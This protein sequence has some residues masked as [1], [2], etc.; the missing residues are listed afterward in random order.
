FSLHKASRSLSKKHKRENNN[1]AI[2]GS[3]STKTTTDC[4][5][6]QLIEYV[7]NHDVK[8]VKKILPHENVNHQNRWKNTALHY[9]AM[10]N[11]NDIIMLLLCDSR[12]D[13]LLKNN[14]HLLPQN[15]YLPSDN[16]KSKEHK[17]IKLEFSLR[18]M[19]DKAVSDESFGVMVSK[20][21]TA[22]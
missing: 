8:D 7:R 11:K 10:S 13:T 22:E 19:L 4:T 21:R 6:T 20:D 17:K 1:L 16:N 5:N 12:T 3:K 18:A 15:C 9:A 14:E 2:E